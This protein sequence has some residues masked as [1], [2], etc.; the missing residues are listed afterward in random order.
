MK[1]K[2]IYVLILIQLTHFNSLAQS[3]AGFW[4]VD[5]V[6]VGERNLTPVAKWFKYHKDNTSQAGNG[7]TQNDIGTWTY[8]KKKKEFLPVSS[9]G[10]D[11][12]G[13]FKVSYSGGKMTWERIEDGMKVVVHLS[14]ITVMPLSPKDSIAG[15]WELVGKKETLFISWTG[16]YRETKTDGTQSFGYW[17]MDPHHPIFHLVDFNRDV[18]VR[19]FD[20]SFKDDLVTM[21]P[22]NSELIM[23]YKK[24]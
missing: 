16:T 10:P 21:K 22:T 9:K 12:Y 4:K 1:G 17:H 2:L 20:I 6:M 19:V 14:P 18:E 15:M 24:H 7:W 8:V 5:Q 23:T 11:E 13:P 3:P